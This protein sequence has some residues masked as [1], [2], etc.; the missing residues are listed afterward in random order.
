MM[1]LF[2]FLWRIL[3]LAILYS[4]YIWVYRIGNEIKKPTEVELHTRKEQSLYTR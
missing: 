2:D 3:V 4:I 1:K